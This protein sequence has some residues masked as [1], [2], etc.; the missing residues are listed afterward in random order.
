[1]E[2]GQTLAAI[3]TGA[4]KTREALIGALVTDAKTAIEKAKTDG[5]ITADQSTQ[6]ENN[7]TARITKLVDS[8]EPAGRGPRR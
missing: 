2:G 3:A 8:T 4:G 6:L 5:K 7:L 1:M